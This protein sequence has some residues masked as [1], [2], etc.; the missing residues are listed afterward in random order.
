MGQEPHLDTAIT[1]LAFVSL[2]T[3][4]QLLQQTTPPLL[5]GGRKQTL[6]LWRRAVTCSDLS[7][8][9]SRI[10]MFFSQYFDF[11]M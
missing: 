3:I 1:F 2:L 11:G 10:Y 6:G 9:H 8:S 5:G 4:F 7:L